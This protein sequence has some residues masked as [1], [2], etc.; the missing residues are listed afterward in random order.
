M[1]CDLLFELLHTVRWVTY[2]FPLVL[3]H[4]YMYKIPLS[5]TLIL[6]LQEMYD[7]LL[8]YKMEY[9]QQN[10]FWN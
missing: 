2:T 1:K 7:S 5:A 10:S 3:C 9:V 8:N 6:Y 4:F